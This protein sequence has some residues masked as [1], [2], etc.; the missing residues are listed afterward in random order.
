MNYNKYKFTKEQFLALPLVDA[1]K[2]KEAPVNTPILVTIKDKFQV[3]S[4]M[5]M[6]EEVGVETFNKALEDPDKQIKV[7]FWVKFPDGNVQSRSGHLVV[8]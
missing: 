8:G 5:T 3:E 1:E 4:L 2:L 7:E 6:I